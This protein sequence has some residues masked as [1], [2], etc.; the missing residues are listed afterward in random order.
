MPVNGKMSTRSL[1][2]KRANRILGCIK[3]SITSWS[4]EVIIS[5][6]SA[7]VQPHLQ[8]CVQFWAPQFKKDVKVL[9]YVQR[10]ATNLVKGLE[11]MSYKERLRTL[12]LSSLEKRRLRGDLIALCSFRKKGSGERGADLFLLVSSDRTHGNGSKLHQGRVRLDIRK[13]FFTERVVKHRLP[14]EVVDAP[15]LSVFK[16]HLD[17]ALNNML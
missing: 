11:G 10:R 2:A 3:H 7:L 9:E 6:Y 4:K 16:R 14:R 13:H 15:S 12:D 5:L 8:Y 1:A 17:N